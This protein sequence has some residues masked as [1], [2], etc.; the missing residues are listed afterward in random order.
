MQKMTKLLTQ[1]R[2]QSVCGRILS[3]QCNVCFSVSKI[4]NKYLG[5]RKCLLEA[6]R[7]FH[8]EAAFWFPESVMKHLLFCCN[9]GKRNDVVNNAAPFQV[10]NLSLTPIPLAPSLSGLAF[11]IPSLLRKGSSVPCKAWLM[12]RKQS[13]C[14]QSVQSDW[15]MNTSNWLGSVTKGDTGGKSYAVDHWDFQPVQRCESEAT[16]A[17]DAV[18]TRNIF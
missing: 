7:T 9:L 8:D 17:A 18:L 1:G 3:V 5:Q 16:P 12:L 6:W 11:A 4:I 10:S 14:L 2:V 13:V 15:H